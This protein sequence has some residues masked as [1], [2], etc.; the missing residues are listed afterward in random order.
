M[1]NPASNQLDHPDSLGGSQKWP[2]TSLK[3][4][5]ETQP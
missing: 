5:F 1:E 2:K 4:G 3:N